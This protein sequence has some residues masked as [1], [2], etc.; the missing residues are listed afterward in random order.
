MLDGLDGWDCFSCYYMFRFRV[1][2]AQNRIFCMYASM[3]FWTNECK[4]ASEKGL[5]PLN[6]RG[7]SASAEGIMRISCRRV[8]GRV[9]SSSYL[10]YAFSLL[11]IRVALT[12]TSL[13]SDYTL[14]HH[15]PPPP[16]VGHSYSSGAFPLTI[17]V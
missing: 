7:C 14:E 10:I 3:G 2:A 5:V 8:G 17:S 13:V 15:I 1:R 6:G 9:R 4:C 12:G 11:R 16:V